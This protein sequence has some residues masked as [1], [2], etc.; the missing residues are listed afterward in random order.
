MTSHERWIATGVSIAFVSLCLTSVLVLPP[1]EGF[2]E[3]AHYSYIS[4]LAD[5]GQI[6]DFRSTPLDASFPEAVGKLPDCY[7]K[8]PDASGGQGLTYAQFFREVPLDQRRAAEREFWQAHGQ[9]ARY[10]PDA[11]LNWQGQHPPLYYALMVVPTSS[12]G[13][14]RSASVSSACDSP[15]SSWPP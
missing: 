15:P 1:R 12:C 7:L 2:D 3:N 11:D 10:R 9:P 8:P 4:F 5:C 13:R 14:R 6:P